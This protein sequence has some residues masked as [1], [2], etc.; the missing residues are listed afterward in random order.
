M[1]VR[2]NP[3][4]ILKNGGIGIIHH[5]GGEYVSYK[6]EKR[7]FRS[8]MTAETFKRIVESANMKVIEQNRDLVHKK[9]DMIAVFVKS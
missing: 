7:G 2:F 9:G 3:A 5:A 8:K 4:C 6:E 1:Y